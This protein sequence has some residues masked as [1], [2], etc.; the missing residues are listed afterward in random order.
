[1]KYSIF[2]RKGGKER[3]LQEEIQYFERRGGKEREFC[4]NKDTG[5]RGK[6]SCRTF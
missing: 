4:I 2:E 3:E 1:M 5:M 6:S